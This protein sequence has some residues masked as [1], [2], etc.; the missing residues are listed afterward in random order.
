MKTFAI[1]MIGATLALCLD[2]ALGG[3]PGWALGYAVC[4]ALLYA[5]LTIDFRKTQRRG[6]CGGA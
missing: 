3:R 6:N 1:G 2:R 4:A 5:A